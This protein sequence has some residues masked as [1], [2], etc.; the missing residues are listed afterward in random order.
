MKDAPWIGMCAED[1]EEQSSF[2]DE[3][4]EDYLATKAD[5]EWKRRKEE[6]EV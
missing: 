6:E 2:Y 5:D 1:Y 4:Y 3:E